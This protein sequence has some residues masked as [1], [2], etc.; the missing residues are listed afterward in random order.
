MKTKICTFKLLFLFC[1]LLL[2]LP[3]FGQFEKDYSLIQYKGTLPSV[4]DEKAPNF[5]DYT[6]EKLDEVTTLRVKQLYE[7]AFYEKKSM[8][9]NGDLY[10]NEVFVTLANGIRNKLIA[11]QPE[12]QGKI[13][14]YFT[15]FSSANAFALPEGSVF[16]NV[17]LLS[18]LEN[19]AQLAFIIGHEIAHVQLAHAY[20]R[21]VKLSEVEQEEKNNYNPLGTSFRKLRYS[22]EDEFEA[23]AQSLRMLIAAGY[24]PEEAS[25]ALLLLA[26]SVGFKVPDMTKRLKNLFES[27]E[28]KL[29]SSL[30]KVENSNYH[31]PKKDLIFSHLKDDLYETHPDMG[32]RISALKEMTRF[33]KYDNKNSP[34]VLYNDQ[35][36]QQLR[37]TAS[38]ESVN[39]LL[40][41]GFYNQSLYLG[42]Y[43]TGLYPENGFLKTMIAKNLYFISYY[44]EIEK[45]DD[46]LAHNILIQDESLDTLNTMLSKMGHNELKKVF[47]EYTSKQHAVNA[48]D[49]DLYLYYAL[50]TEVFIGK[51][52]SK[53]IYNEYLMRFPAGR[54]INFA[55]TKLL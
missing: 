3:V 32:K 23:D 46:V 25:K 20:K 8:V 11:Q 13:N 31:T 6:K 37:S 10:F 7:S 53:F 35:E 4:F 44:K 19:E 9:Y 39:N 5:Q 54:H 40:Y 38:F 49:E 15:R 45:L 36:Y 43:M 41:K 26:D 34:Y 55:K 2:D 27:D 42:I 14:I 30:F 1:V 24:A 17:G 29:D 22:R 28:I 47:F 21:T 16:I 50:A 12:L 18:K 51:E 48:E 52:P 33:L